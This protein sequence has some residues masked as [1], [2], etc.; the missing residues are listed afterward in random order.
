MLLESL[1]DNLVARQKDTCASVRRLAL[2]GLANVAS[3]SPNK[4]SQ[5]P[6][7]G[8]LTVRWTDHLDALWGQGCAWRWPRELVGWGAVIL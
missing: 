6:A 2:R 3:G 1:L 4:V 5:P 8:A 7:P